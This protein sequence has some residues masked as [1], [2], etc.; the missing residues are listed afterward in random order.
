MRP[1][2][3]FFNCYHEEKRKAN[4]A[5][6]IAMQLVVEDVHPSYF[7]VLPPNPKFLISLAYRKGLLTLMETL[8]RSIYR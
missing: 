5:C 6:C 8:K 2:Y 1:S 3:Y 7:K 4:K